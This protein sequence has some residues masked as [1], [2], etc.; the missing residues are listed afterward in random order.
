[1]GPVDWFG[2]KRLGKRHRSWMT[3]LG[4]VCL[5]SLAAWAAPHVVR[6]GETKMMRVGAVDAVMGA[7]G[8]AWGSAVTGVCAGEGLTAEF[9]GVD[10]SAVWRPAV[11]NWGND[12]AARFRIVEG[13]QVGAAPRGVPMRVWTFSTMQDVGRVEVGFDVRVERD[14]DVMRVALFGLEGEVV[15]AVHASVDGAG[16]VLERVEGEGILFSGTLEAW[17]SEDADEEEGRA[18]T[19]GMEWWA[20]T[21]T[22]PSVKARGMAISR[23]LTLG[24]VAAVQFVVESD[25]PRVAMEGAE[26]MTEVTVYRLLVPVEMEGGR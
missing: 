16:A 10:A 9:E 26:E 12:F 4:W 23:R 24:G 20:M 21:E 8:A 11:A 22:L 6:S 19:E 14:G 3:A 1:V 25:S 13:A 2:F 18:M 7:G 5:F 15:G 17:G